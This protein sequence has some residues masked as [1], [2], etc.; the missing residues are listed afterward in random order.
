MNP[1][2]GL[3]LWTT[4]NGIISLGILFL[5]YWYLVKPLFKKAN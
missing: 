5:I 3:T 1:A 4:L 2:G